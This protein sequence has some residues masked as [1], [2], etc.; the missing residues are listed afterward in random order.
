MTENLYNVLGV[1]EKSTKDEIKKA[2]RGLQMKWHPD[3]NQGSEDSKKMSEKINGAY[4]VLGD[5]EKRLEYDNISKSP[6]ARMNSGGMEVPMDD[7]LNMFFKGMPGF[8]GMSGFPGMPPGAKVHVFNGSPMGFNQAISKPIPIMKTIEINMSQV[9]SGA[10]IP[11]EIE[12]W[13]IENQIKVFEKETIYVTVPKGIDDNEMII[14]RDSGNVL[15]ENV[16]GDIK[17]FVKIKNETPFKRVGLDL[18]LNK[19]ISLKD[20]LCGFT[21]ELDYINGKSYTLNNNKG[22]II[23]SGYK[24]IYQGMGLTR[25][26]HKGNMIIQFNVIFPDKLTEEQIVKLTEIL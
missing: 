20:S 16:K 13:I 22:N 7:I 2:Y 10:S 5:D 26:D 18:I 1:D 3:R 21:F 14:L 24:K 19:T 25:G 15:N 12:R 9:L 11:L 4:E 17:I 6:F 23:P 8:P